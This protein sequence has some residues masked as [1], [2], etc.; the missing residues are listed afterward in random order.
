M[1]NNP[2]STKTIV[3]R[4]AHLVKGLWLQYVLAVGGAVLGFL[5]TILIPSLVIRLAWQ[6]LDGQ[7]PAVA[8]VFLLFALGLLR[9]ILRYMEHFFGHYVAF[10][11]L[12]DFRCM[13]FAKLRRLAPT[14]LDK[15]DSGNML[16]MIGED[17]E[18]M[19]VFF[20][21]TLPPVMTATLV[22]IILA[23][24][25]WSVSPLIAVVSLVVYAFLAIFLPRAQAK[26]LQPLLQ[27]QSQTRKTYMSHFSDNLH[28]MKELLQFGRIEPALKQLNQ[29]SESVNA[30]EKEVAQAQHLQS[31]LSFL[32][33]GL[34]IMG[35]AILSL[36]QAEAG[37]ITLVS[38]VTVIVVFSTSFAPYLELSRLPLGFKRAMTAARQVFEL[39]DEKE[40]DK[41]GQAFD[42]TI[43]SIVLEDVSF[44][45]DNREQDIFKHLSVAFENHKIIGL[46]GQSGSGKST[47]MKLVM[48]WYD[49][50]KGQILVNQHPLSDLSAR[51]IQSHIAYI[52]QIPQVFS[53]TIRENL[54]LGNPDITDDMILEA[55]A[56]CR[57]KDKILSTKNG[58]DTLLNSEQTVFSAGELQ[59]LELTRALL[60]EADCYIFDEPTS[61]LDS[62]N[63]AAFLQVVRKHCKGYVF[64]I[65]HRLSTVA[66]SDVIYKVENKTLTQV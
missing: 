40:F 54:T 41:S 65:S 47:L 7:T 32:V 4:L 12:Y 36:S 18:A 55:A 57:I 16:K 35:V 10:K 20:A 17:I 61:N 9:G 63:E 43:D 23:V 6:A 2:L 31:S 39:L 29:E 42:E 38:A 1:S 21:H 64:L 50:T 60:K 8:F 51:D 11:T 37:Q 56:K 46:V 30:R 49:N 33:I 28:G 25:Y 5:M 44:T 48:R 19:E 22:T 24:Y 45:Y 15:Q 58:L 26:H 66:A 53:Q 59:R 14:K 3:K 27:K 62:L 13:V 34:A 52:P